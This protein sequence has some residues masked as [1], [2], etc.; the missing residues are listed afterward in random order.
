MPT[1]SRSIVEAA[2]LLAA[3]TCLTLLALMFV[4]GSGTPSA[5]G[6]PGPCTSA[7]TQHGSCFNRGE[8]WQEACSPSGNIRQNSTFQSTSHGTYALGTGILRY[9]SHDNQFIDFQCGQGGSN[10]WHLTPQGWVSKTTVF[11]T[12]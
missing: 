11:R 3:A 2:V 7:H 1:K 4:V 10:D 9:G 12:N 5:T 6:S 8:R